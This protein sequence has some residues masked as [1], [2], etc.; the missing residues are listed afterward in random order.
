MTFPQFIITARYTAC[1]KT[2]IASEVYE[3][4]RA[5]YDAID[6]YD[7]PEDVIEVIRLDVGGSWAFVTDE[8]HQIIEES[9]QEAEDLAVHYRSFAPCRQTHGAL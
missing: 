4:E 6:S 7:Y 3:T 2:V 8:A 5:Y 9:Q 1:G